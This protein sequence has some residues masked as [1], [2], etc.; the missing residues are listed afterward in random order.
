LYFRDDYDDI[1]SNKKS[2]FH[3]TLLMHFRVSQVSG[4]HLRGFT[5]GPTQS[6]LQRWRVVGNVS[7]IWSAL[8]LNPIP[9]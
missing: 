7:E 8:D 4:A 9:H 1:Y 2:N 6:M 3:Y 5:P